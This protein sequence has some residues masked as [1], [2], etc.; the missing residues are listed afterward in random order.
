MPFFCRRIAVA[1]T[2]TKKIIDFPAGV[3]IHALL[4]KAEGGDIMLSPSADTANTGLTIT[5]GSGIALSKADLQSITREN[6][7][8][9]AYSAAGADVEVFGILE[10]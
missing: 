6:K 1:A 5:D 8:L 3:A 4:V 7:R 9:Y 10:W 2:A